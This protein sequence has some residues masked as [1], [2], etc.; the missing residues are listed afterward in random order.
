MGNE[1]REYV[2]LCPECNESMK[3]DNSMRDALIERGCVICGATVTTDAFTKD[4]S[5][6]AT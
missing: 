3:L 5:P 6:D 1:C 2:F 4:S